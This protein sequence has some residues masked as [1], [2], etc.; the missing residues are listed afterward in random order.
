MKGTFYIQKGLCYK[1]NTFSK[2]SHPWV[3]LGEPSSDQML[4][5]K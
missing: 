2:D 4:W 5:T 1:D 3:R